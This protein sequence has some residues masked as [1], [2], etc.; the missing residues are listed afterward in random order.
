MFDSVSLLTMHKIG[1]RPI[2]FNEKIFA[3]CVFFC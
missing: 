3:R 1:M 2:P